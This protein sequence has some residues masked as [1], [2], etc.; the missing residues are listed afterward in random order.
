[1]EL[2]NMIIAPINALMAT[3]SH[4]Y[5]PLGNDEPTSASGG[6]DT[7]GQHHRNRRAL[8]FTMAAAALLTLGYVTTLFLRGAHATTNPC[9]TP[10]DGFQCNAATTHSWG[11][12]SPFFSVP[13][14]LDASVPA[15]CHLTFA[16]ILSRHG[17]RDP[18]A[19]KTASYNASIVKIHNTVTAYGAGYEFIKDYQYTLGADQL[20]ALGQEQMVNSG[21]KFYNRYKALA[22]KSLP[23]VRAS[24]QDRVV[25]SAQNFTQGLNQALLA[26]RKCRAPA[27]TTMLV[28]PEAAGVN[29]T[30]NH[31]LC[32]AFESGKYSTVGST[33]QAAFAAVFTTPIAAR[34]ATNLP[35]MTFSASAVVSFMD[36]CPFNTVASPT[37]ALSPFCGLFTPA[38][39]ADY[40]YYQTLGKWYGYGPGNPLGPTQGVGYVNE[41]IARLTRTPVN[42]STS[43]NST[44]DGS[45]ATF[46]LER[47][48]YADFSH[49][50]DMTGVLGALGVYAATKPLSTAARQ[51]PAE[52]GG[53]AASWTVPFGAR[54]YVEKMVCGGGGS[55]EEMV[56]VLVND[57]VV[58]LV[59]CNADALGRCALGKFVDSL[60][61]ARAGGLWSQCFV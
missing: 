12:Y 2:T 30:M 57:R 10:E 45:A 5:S 52:T 28:I 61:F 24:G 42:D 43:T 38:E 36:L 29:N 35:G 21:I 17:A 31:N 32:T 39:W 26:D 56:R 41:L 60:A 47:A 16:Q 11:Q 49:D 27:N 46:P 34:L 40:D 55:A 58:P 19:S 44:L 48:L 18:T 15:G 8:K 13:S 37:G 14:E 20:T 1:M 50:N 6:R 59:G 3:T 23:F 54:I 51:S 9:D 4:K 53:Y 33:A 7:T 25:Q 22:S